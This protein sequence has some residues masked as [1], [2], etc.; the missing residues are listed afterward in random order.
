MQAPHTQEEFIKLVQEHRAMLYKVCRLYCFSEDD[1]QD[2]FQEIV[3]QLWRAYPAF[4]GES[5]FSTWLY[6]IALNTAISNLRKQRRRPSPLNINELPASLQD[7]SYPGEEEEQL[8]QLYAAIDR[9]SEIE[10]ALVML[11]LE[12]RSYEEMEEILGIN[13]NNLRVK[14]NRIR[15]KLRKMTKEATYGIR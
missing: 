2:L 15:E 11:Y 7:M 4:R 13:Q 8:Q 12:D 9:L 1:R 6:R 14:M 5:K 10:K 3:I